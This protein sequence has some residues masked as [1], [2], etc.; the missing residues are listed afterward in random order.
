M[1]PLIGGAGPAS[2]AG[3]GVGSPGECC[4]GAEAACSVLCGAAVAA[5]L[6]G[7]KLRAG[8]KGKC[9]ERSQWLTG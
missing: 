5:L 2:G 1:A 9:G 7:H 6:S 4:W 8:P 3:F